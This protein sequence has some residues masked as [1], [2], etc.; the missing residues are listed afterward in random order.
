MRPSIGLGFVL[1]LATLGVAPAA[2]AEIQAV[3]E[4]F[5]SQ[6]CSSCPPADRLAGDLARDERLIVLSMPVDYWDYLGWNDTLAL[7]SHTQRQKAYAAVRGD[8]QVYTPQVVVDGITQ[9]VGSERGAIEHAVGELKGKLALPVR[10]E[11]KDGTLEID[12]GA[13]SGTPAA[14]LLLTVVH[15]AVAQVTEP[16]GQHTRDVVGWR[17]HCERIEHL[18][19]DQLTHRHPLA[20][21]RHRVE[22]LA[23]LAPAVQL[24]HAA[25]S[26][27]RAV[28]RDLLL[29]GRGGLLHLLVVRAG[30]HEDRATQ[31][32]VSGRLLRPRIQFRATAS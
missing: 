30:D 3:I 10:I 27:R 16:L 13:G 5:T 4:L 6:G 18:V 15:D 21:L 8:R 29:R 17:H 31:L 12:V 28:E 20:A 2:A 25:V 1:A 23:D 9:C 32:E 14:V 19:G 11:R 7:H 26:G 24:E 22:L